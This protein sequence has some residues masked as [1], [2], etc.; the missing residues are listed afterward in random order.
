MGW[1]KAMN[2]IA[3]RLGAV[4][5]MAALAL[6]PLRAQAAFTGLYV[7]GDSLSDR[8]NLLALSGG[9]APVSPSYTGGQFSNGPSWTNSFSQRL[10]LGPSAPSL[11]GGRVYAFG[12]ARTDT[13][14]PGLGLPNAINIP[15]QVDAYIGGPNAPAGA[16]FGM[17]GGANNMLQAMAALGS[18]PPQNWGS[19]LAGQAAAAAGDVVAQLNRLYQDGARNFLVLNLPDLGRTPRFNTEP[20]LAGAARGASQAFN[21]A[22]AQGLAAFEAQ[23]GVRLHTLDIFQLFE[24]VAAAPGGFGFDNIATPCITGAVPDIYVIPAAATLNCTPQQ[25]ARTLFWDPIHPSA[26]AHELIGALAA[27]AVPVPG[28]LALLL[29]PM[30][31]LVVLRRQG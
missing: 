13:V 21:A 1:E 18:V 12:L 19:F 4:F 25:A 7:F 9:G 3:G 20:V 30:G 28:A 2:A 23:P 31:L 6:A 17:W 26:A 10:G 22:L 27:Q 11:L 15:N 8:G 24:R 29:L 5:L 14:A 16:L